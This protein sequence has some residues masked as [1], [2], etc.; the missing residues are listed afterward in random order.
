MIKHFIEE[1]KIKILIVSC[2]LSILDF[3]IYHNLELVL[4]KNHNL[5]DMTNIGLSVIKKYL[6]VK[7]VLIFNIPTFIQRGCIQNIVNQLNYHEALF[8]KKYNL[9][10]YDTKYI[11]N[12]NKNNVQTRT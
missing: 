3:A 7:K 8:V 5:N 11:L 4:S 9:L 12:T 6:S 2:D 10:N 1:T